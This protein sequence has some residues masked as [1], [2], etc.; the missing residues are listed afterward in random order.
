MKKVCVPGRP[1]HPVLCVA[2]ACRDPFA[3]TCVRHLP[4]GTATLLHALPVAQSSGLVSAGLP[5]PPP[6]PAASA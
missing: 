5:A 2:T 3:E 4:R 6:S 1:S